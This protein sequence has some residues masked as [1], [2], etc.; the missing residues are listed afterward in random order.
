MQTIKE[1]EK[2][3]VENEEMLRKI[4]GGKF[5]GIN[6]NFMQ[7]RED[8]EAYRECYCSLDDV[9]L[10]LL[11]YIEKYNNDDRNYFLVASDLLN[12]LY[13]SN[14]WAG[15]KQHFERTNYFVEALGDISNE[16]DDWNRVYKLYD[17]IKILLL[18]PENITVSELNALGGQIMHNMTRWM[19][20]KQNT[21]K[22]CNNS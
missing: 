10:K 14:R 12:K 15:L 18:Q 2:W 11:I 1:I 17:D 6:S 19:K 9:G 8:R 13:I 21:E 5:C 3:F 4:M 7:I 22:N 16:L 20:E